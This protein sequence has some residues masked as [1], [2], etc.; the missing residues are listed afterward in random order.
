MCPHG[1]WVS[2]YVSEGEL[3]AVAADTDPRFGNL[4][5]RGRLAP[6]IVYSPDR[7]RT[8]LVRSG[9]KGKIQFR[10]ATWDEALDKIAEQFIDI[11]NRYGA[12]ALASYMGAGTLEDGLSFLKKCSSRSVHRTT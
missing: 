12:R 5:E 11:R 8:P 3:V 10:E 2:A 1:C 9:P 6:R 4:C 7:I